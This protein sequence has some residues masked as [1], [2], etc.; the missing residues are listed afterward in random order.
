MKRD[1][2]RP[3]LVDPDLGLT[4]QDYK[5]FTDPNSYKKSG[6]GGGPMD[7]SAVSSEPP[8][9]DLAEI[10]ASPKPPKLGETQLVSVAVTD[11]VPLK[12]VLIELARLADVD[13]EVDAGITGGVSFRAKDRPFNEVIDRITDLAGLR[14]SM[15]GNILRVERDTPR[16][17]IYSLDFLNIE[18]SANGNVSIS[19][20]V[21]SSGGGGGSS[22]GSGGGGGGSSGGSSGGSGGA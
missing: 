8:V 10:L 22:G 7:L 6:P 5:N 9:P 1:P 15:K 13:I 20:S 19:T 12:D 21:L 14:Y 16:V 3:D 4:R 11:D 18:R 17:E 2:Q